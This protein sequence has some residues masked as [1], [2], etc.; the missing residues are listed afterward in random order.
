M[1][2]LLA[3]GGPQFRRRVRFVLFGRPDALASL[4]QFDGNALDVGG[5][6][7]ERGAV[8][9]QPLVGT[10]L[11]KLEQRLLE[12]GLGVLG[13]LDLL[14]YE[15]VDFADRG[16]DAGLVRDSLEHELARD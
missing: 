6:P 4:C 9:T 3:T 13:V 16:V 10:T 5:E 12:L 7:V 15:R 14:A 1:L 11:A 8:L 2:A